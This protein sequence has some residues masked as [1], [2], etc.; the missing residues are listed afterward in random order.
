[1]KLRSVLAN[2]LAMTVATGTV[3]AQTL[4][5]IMFRTG[6]QTS[7]LNPILYD[8]DTVTGTAT[9]PRS[10]NVNNCVGIAVDHA[11]GVMYGLTDQFGRINNQSGTGGKNLIF[12]INPATGAAVAVGRVDPSGGFQVFEGDIAF[13]PVDGGMWGVSTLINAARLFR[14]DKT[15]GLATLGPMISP[16]IG[17]DLDISALTFNAAGEMF[18]LDTR[19]PANPGP[20]IIMKL[21]AQTGAPLASWNTGTI[22]GNCAGMAFASDGTLFIADGDTSGTNRLYRFDFTTGLMTDIGPTNA[23]GGIYRGLAGLVF[24]C[25]AARITAPPSD[26]STC[27][28]GGASFAIAATNA[29]EIRWSVADAA[30]PDAWSQLVD[31]PVTLGGDGIGTASGTTTTTMQFQ[32]AATNLRPLRFRAS[33]SG[34]CGSEDSLPASLTICIGEFNCDGGVDG[35]DIEAFFVA[36]QAGDPDADVN[37][38][39]G[40]D[41]GDIE[42]FFIRWERGC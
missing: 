25:V 37:A 6:G 15:T 19:Y 22:L 20:S 28:S 27:P 12:T 10:V 2:S 40:V 1:M 16:V 14:V 31:G 30:N 13:N 9:N 39:G 32:N 3:Q 21:N 29:S 4:H 18:V 38:D 7:G 5:G 11:T 36:W 41:G 23:A 26:A 17:T 42:A 35:T 33:V 8:V 34:S 24:R